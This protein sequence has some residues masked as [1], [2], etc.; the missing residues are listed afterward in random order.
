MSGSAAALLRHLRQFC[1]L[2]GATRDEAAARLG[3]PLGTLKRRLQKARRLL[4]ERLTRRGLTLSAA[5]VTALL[6]DASRAAVPA[7]LLRGVSGFGGTAGV[8]AP[9]AALAEGVIGS[10]GGLRW[11]ALVGLVLA[12]GAGAGVLLQAGE[13]VKPSAPVAEAKGDVTPNAPRPDRFGDPL[14]ECAVARI[15]TLRFRHDGGVVQAI[16]TP[17]GKR[18]ISCAGKFIYVWDAETGTGLHRWPAGSDMVTA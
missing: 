4:H 6:T 3:W 7:A 18:I 13:S 2:E 1:Y 12:A 5:L 9:V 8:S 16:P 17:D 15:G 11:A 10:A 14:P